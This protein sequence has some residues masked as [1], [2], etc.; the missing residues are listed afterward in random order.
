MDAM[1]AVL[2]R[3][4]ADRP[5]AADPQISTAPAVYD[6]AVVRASKLDH[7]GELW[8]KHLREAVDRPQRAQLREAL[9]VLRAELPTPGPRAAAMR[10]VRDPDP[11]EELVSWL[12]TRVA[13]VNSVAQQ[14]RQIAVFGSDTVPHVRDGER[15][16]AHYLDWVDPTL[17]VS[18]PDY[19]QWG[20]F[21]RGEAWRRSLAWLCLTLREVATAA[22]LEAWIDRF[23]MGSNFRKPVPL[24]R[25]EGPA[26]PIFRVLD[27]GTHRAHFARVFGLPL[28]ARVRTSALPQP[29]LPSD[30]P[31]SPQSP[32]RRWESL[33]RGLR[34]HGLLD[35]IEDLA[36]DQATWTVTRLCAEWML[37]PP[38]AA[39]AVNRAY[40]QAYPHTLQRATG[41]S[42]AQL[43]DAEQWTRT[44]VGPEL[45]DLQTDPIRTPS[46]WASLRN[47]FIS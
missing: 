29:L 2:R 47:W 42:D 3:F 21:D 17:I 16:Q 1:G 9:A 6:A 30:R 40:A 27:D 10:M 44:F 11:G 35:V 46:R 28:L 20:Q 22:D 38:E 14:V 34:A 32:F 18:T 5:L 37:M 7:P 24:E 26:G 4:G 15:G 36:A 8:A 31:P 45:V 33:W 23:M 19:E 12:E 39:T 41:L 43:F 13:Q 25:V